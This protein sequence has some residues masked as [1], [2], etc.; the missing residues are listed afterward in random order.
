MCRLCKFPSKTRTAY[1]HKAV[2]VI[3]TCKDLEERVTQPLSRISRISRGDVQ[4]VH[5]TAEDALR[6]LE[7]GEKHPKPF[8]KFHEA[9]THCLRDTH[10]SLL[11]EFEE[12]WK[13]VEDKDWHRG[14]ALKR[15]DERLK[16]AES[17][18]RVLLPVS[19]YTSYDIILDK[20][21]N[22]GEQ[23]S[24]N[25]LNKSEVGKATT[26][27]TSTVDCAENDSIE[28]LQ[29]LFARTIYKKRHRQTPLLFPTSHFY[30][31]FEEGLQSL[32]FP[33]DER[34]HAKLYHDQPVAIILDHA[35]DP[36]TSHEHIDPVKSGTLIWQ[37]I[38]NKQPLFILW[39]RE[40]SFYFDLPLPD[41]EN[42]R[43][44]N[45]WCLPSGSE[46][47]SDVYL[48][49]ALRGDLKSSETLMRALSEDVILHVPTNKD[50]PRRMNW[51]DVF[52]EIHSCPENVAVADWKLEV[53][54]SKE[55]Q[56]P[57]RGNMHTP[58][59][60][61]K[62][63]SNGTHRTAPSLGHEVIRSRQSQ[64]SDRP[65]RHASVLPTVHV[66]GPTSPPVSEPRKTTFSPA[67]SNQKPHPIATMPSQSDPPQILQTPSPSPA[68]RPPPVTSA[69]TTPPPTTPPPLHSETARQTDTAGQIPPVPAR[70]HSAPPQAKL[71][72]WRRAWNRVTG[73]ST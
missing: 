5:N 29:W 17:G 32:M 64:P 43:F 67:P 59:S 33:G 39:D 62:G 49:K 24:S 16:K 66:Q 13:K 27:L 1:F 37:L 73:T 14:E 61:P 15:I 57:V 41:H 65:S 21:T 18:K 4:T 6:R 58:L 28:G 53:P 51:N 38:L 8:H 34:V 40:L 70:T 44:K 56:Q 3:R 36:N 54:P 68:P 22:N 48:L 55:A 45:I 30:E 7:N 10:K 69:S 50:R 52:R 60:L 42:R 9:V 35:Q 26:K 71:G 20:D 47:G 25:T 12:R 19:Y 72:F 46:N 63:N 2:E 31:N 11:D 23:M